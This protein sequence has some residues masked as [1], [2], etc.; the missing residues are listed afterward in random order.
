MDYSTRDLGFTGPAVWETSSTVL[1][2]TYQDGQW[3]ALRLGLDGT[4][5]QALDPVRAGDLANPWRW[6][7]RP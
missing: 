6:G 1:V 5:T 2:T 4:M 3:Y 7:L